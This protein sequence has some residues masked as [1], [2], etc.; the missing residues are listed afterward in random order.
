MLP[1]YFGGFVVSF[2]LAQETTTVLPTGGPTSA[3]PTNSTAGNTTS[4]V[5]TTTTT[6][7][8]TTAVTK[9]CPIGWCLDDQWFEGGP[10]ITPAPNELRKCWNDY[11]TAD[12]NHRGIY[13]TNAQGHQQGTFCKEWQDPKGRVC[14]H[15]IE[16]SCHCDS[17]NS[18][19]FSLS[20]RDGWS[21]ADP[22]SYPPP[23]E[24]TTTESPTTT[25]G[26]PTTTTTTG[27]PT[28]SGPTG[29]TTSSGGAT[30][31]GPTSAATHVEV[32]EVIYKVFIHGYRIYFYARGSML[33]V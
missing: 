23:P 4:T 6:T 16:L 3:V 9:Y 10:C 17:F 14:F 29:A 32:S 30:T 26:S 28:T 31:V 1:R 25:A 24:P 22:C 21:V 18:T 15:D 11:C 12:A 19:P 13:P 2:V 33:L 20:P 27:S 5:T 7:T 8:S